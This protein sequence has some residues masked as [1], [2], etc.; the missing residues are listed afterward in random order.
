MGVLACTVGVTALAVGGGPKLNTIFETKAAS[1]SFTFDAA[2]GSQFENVPCFQTIDVMT[3]VSDPIH[4]EVS[5]EFIE[6]LTFGEGERF[7]EAHPDSEQCG[8]FLQI[9][10]N[11]LT[12]FEIDMGVE[13]DA[14]SSEDVY[15]VVL[16]DQY[17]SA[18]REWG[19]SPFE[20]DGNGNGTAHLEWDKGDYD[21]T[22]VEVC[23]SLVFLDDSDEANLY[24]SSLSLSW[25]C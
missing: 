6:S 4:T 24:V 12:H 18:V 25:N 10:I 1:K 23:V 16:R 5:P 2:T 20:L 9:G 17:R 22:V 14:G 21:G 15:M 11:N 13:S 8:Y 7:V 3:G 19:N